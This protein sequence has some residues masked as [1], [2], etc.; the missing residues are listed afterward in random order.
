MEYLNKWASLTG[1]HARLEANLFDSYIVYMDAM[2]RVVK[3][4]ADG[5]IEIIEEADNE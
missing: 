3:E 2:E 5:R 1:E 4:F